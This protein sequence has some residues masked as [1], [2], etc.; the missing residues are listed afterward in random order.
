MLLF[1]VF[2]G[3]QDFTVERKPDAVVVMS[4]KGREALRY[5]IERPAESKLAVE[6]G[7]YFHPLATPSGVVLTDVAPSDHLHH[8]G[9]FLAWVEMHGAKDADFWGWGQQAPKNGRKIVNKEVTLDAGGFRAQNEWRAEDTV[10]VR[11]NLLVAV[12]AVPSANIVDL[13]YTFSVAHEMKIA[14]WAFSGFCVRLRKD[15]KVEAEGPDGVVKYAEPSHTNPKSDWPAAAWY[16]FTLTLP[17][18]TLAGAAVLEHPKNPPS[19]WYNHRGA[20]ML[21]P[22][23]TAPGPVVLMPKEPLVLRYRVVAHDGPVP[24]DL[25]NRLVKEF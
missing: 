3:C 12:R 13:T 19:L 17:D 24:R 1:A 25:L 8:R 16:D 22:S 15:G 11:E 5:Q 23:L 7:C 21:N 10:L 14:Q 4:P 20:R 6:S 2:L 18:G 9:V